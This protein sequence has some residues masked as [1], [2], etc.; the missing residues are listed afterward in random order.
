MI[1]RDTEKT[2]ELTS[3]FM[4]IL[5]LLS[6]YRKL[7]PDGSF[8]SIT[9]KQIKVGN[10]IKVTHSQR[11]PADMILIKSSDK[12][13][14]VFVKTDQLDGETDWKFRESIT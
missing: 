13:G 11:V 4:S 12:S 3:L 8:S 5:Y 1:S 6:S 9:S 2:K 7:M 10:I 14:G